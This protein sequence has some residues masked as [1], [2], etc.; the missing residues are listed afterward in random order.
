MT[1]EEDKDESEQSY[2]CVVRE[3]WAIMQRLI[4]D[5]MSGGRTSCY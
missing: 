2:E 3:L 5:N 4:Q 1:F